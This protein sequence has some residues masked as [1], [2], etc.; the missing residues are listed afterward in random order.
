M[1]KPVTRERI[2]DAAL[3]L[4]ADKGYLATTMADIGAE[5]GIRGPSL[6]KHVSSKQELLTNI[7]LETMNNL[8]EARREAI[9]SIDDPVSLLRRIVRDHARYSAEHPEETVV[10]TAE[11]S[12][13]DRENRR[14]IVGLRT[15]F[16]DMLQEVIIRGSERGVFHV[17]SSRLTAFTIIDMIVSMVVWFRPGNPL[18]VE[19]LADYYADTA[20]LLA[21]VNPQAIEQ[22]RTN[23]HSMDHAAESTPPLQMMRQP[24]SS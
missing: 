22:A 20:L 16:V 5:V 14:R 8:I 10:G 23:A 17:R 21:G 4:F 12:H 2:H 19:E 1:R 9:A 24:A 13:L 11:L 15:E 7:I 18:T 6:Y 3:R